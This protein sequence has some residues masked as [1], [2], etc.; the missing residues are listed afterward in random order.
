MSFQ[1]T[2][3]SLI[4]QLKSPQKE[5]S[6]AAL[7]QLCQNYWQP[8]YTWLRFSGYGTDESMDFVQGFFQH[9]IRTKLFE[10]A[11]KQNG[12]LRSF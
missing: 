11:D 10:K 4:T 1:K 7:A 3:W 12:K 5:I 2:A 9:S 6:E 8:L